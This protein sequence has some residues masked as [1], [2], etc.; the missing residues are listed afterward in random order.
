VDVSGRLRFVGHRQ[1]HP[2]SAFQPSGFDRG[3]VVS[4][5]GA[6]DD[7]SVAVAAFEGTRRS[8]RGSCR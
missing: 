6:G 4:I 8:C 5:D 1:A 3:L 2:W 7:L